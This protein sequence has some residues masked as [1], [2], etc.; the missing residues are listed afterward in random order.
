MGS[1]QYDGP[2]VAC[3]GPA[4]LHKHL[5][6]PRHEN[7]SVYL[8]TTNHYQRMKSAN[9]LKLKLNVCRAYHLAK[10]A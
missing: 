1:V 3:S 6:E 9:S 5:L 2:P 10:F 8:G 4:I 7:D